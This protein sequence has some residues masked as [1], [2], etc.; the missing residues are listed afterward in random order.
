MPD[1]RSFHVLEAVANRLEASPQRPRRRWSAEAKSRLIE[2]TL[3][4][5]ANVSAIARQAGMA[6][7]QLFGWR[8]K[9]IT[10]ADKAYDA[11]E[12]VNENVM[13]RRSGE[14]HAYSTPGSAFLAGRRSRLPR[15]CSTHKR[16]LRTSGSE[17]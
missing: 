17:G 16:Q 11:Q 2:A 5:G 3:K 1:D 12:F 4:P 10:R 13:S 14:L 6:P 9:A 8:S 15:R 7:A